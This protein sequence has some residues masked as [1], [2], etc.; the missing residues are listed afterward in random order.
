MSYI[1]SS[2]YKR[3]TWK[4]ISLRLKKNL[5]TCTATM[6]QWCLTKPHTSTLR[7]HT[8]FRSMRTAWHSIYHQNISF[9][10]KNVGAIL[11]HAFINISR[12]AW[13]WGQYCMFKTTLHWSWLHFGTSCNHQAVHSA[14]TRFCVLKQLQPA[15]QTGWL[16][17]V[18]KTALPEI[19]PKNAVSS[20]QKQQP[21]PKGRKKKTN[22][23][24]F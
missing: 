6:P 8:I 14:A 12:H 10:C 17:S 5:L 4:L 19:Q 7:A 18:E 3:I 11:T 9:H 13:R 21:L 16:P 24:I 1:I 23:I 22:K 20:T 2:S 15:Q